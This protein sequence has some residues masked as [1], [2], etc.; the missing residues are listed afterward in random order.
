MACMV[1][2]EVYRALKSGSE[3]FCTPL[4]SLP[5]EEQSVEISDG[6]RTFTAVLIP[7]SDDGKDIFFRIFV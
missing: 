1:S 5:C 2:P 4:G 3:Y 6:E 7:F